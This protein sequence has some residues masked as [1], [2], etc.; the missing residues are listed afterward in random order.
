MKNILRSFYNELEIRV[1]SS[2]SVLFLIFFSLS[3]CKE[4]SR[5]KEIEPLEV[6]KE[7][8]KIP[9]D[10]AF[11]FISPEFEK[12]LIKYK[13]DPDKNLN[14]KIRYEHIKNIDSLDIAFYGISK[15]L[16][17]IEYFTDLKYLKVR[18]YYSTASINP[19]I[20]YYA[21]P[22]GVVDNFVPSIDTLDVSNNLK[23]EYL[24][25]SGTSDGGG[26]ASTIGNLTLGLNV[27][28]K[29]IISNSSMIKSLDL[30]E[31]SAL[32]NLEISSCYNLTSLSLCKNSVLVKLKSWQLKTI[33]VPSLKAV[34]PGWETGAATLVQCK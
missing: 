4:K 21:F 15:S 20:Y 22:I 32:E 30:S 12:L 1:F 34:N 8:L 31:L 14:G 29:I 27:N 11:V 28:L 24:D 23:L 3:G 10:S 6:I 33:S 13:I 26:Y 9:V 17:G 18:G 19:N 7:P 16:K 25:C 5:E 2:L